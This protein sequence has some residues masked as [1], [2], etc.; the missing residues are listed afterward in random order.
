MCKRSWR[1]SGTISHFGLEHPNCPFRPEPPI[2]ALTP[3]LSLQ[4]LIHIGFLTEE[5]GDVF[6]PRV[7]KGGPLGEMVQWADILAALFLLGH[8]LRVTVSLKELQRWVLW[9]CGCC[10]AMG[11]WSPPRVSAP[12]ARVGYI[13]V[14]HESTRSARLGGGFSPTCVSGSAGAVLMQALGGVQTTSITAR[15]DP[16]PSA[17]QES[18]KDWCK[19]RLCMGLMW[20]CLGQDSALW[21]R[22]WI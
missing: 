11:A 4:I 19:V 5:S 17:S 16:I 22:R 3:L 13:E 15:I 12:R 20:R 14:S 10:G 8:S 7:L 21:S 9:C 18:G 6:S 1:E 2:P